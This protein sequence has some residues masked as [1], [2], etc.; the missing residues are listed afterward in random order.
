[1]FSIIIPSYNRKEYIPDLLNSLEHQ[2]AHNFE[3]V[4]VDDCSKEPVEIKHYYS[5]PI[6]LIRNEQNKGAAESRN[7]GARCA[8]NEW[9][10]FLD[11]DDRFALEK[12]EILE[13]EIQQ[14]PSVNFIYHPADCFMVN[15]NFSYIT[16]PVS[17][18]RELSLDMMLK[19]NQIGGMP[20]IGMKRELFLAVD[21]LSQ[22]IMSLEDYEFLLKLIQEPSFKAKY[23]EQP[24]TK[25]TFHTKRSS[26]ST[27]TS[28]T[29][30]AI[31]QIAKKHVRTAQQEKNFAFN[32]LYMLAYP[33]IMNLSRKAGIYYLRMF[34]HSLS[35]KYLIIALITF[36]SP[37][38]AINMKRFV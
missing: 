6:N 2:T 4:I 32:S 1:M 21:G 14:D 38:L 20:M 15:E 17:N 19:V 9:L 12:C 22:D 26:V 16:H 36:I 25:C 10:L 35:V 23:V 18:E 5:F 33:N 11:D 28:N 8:K 31:K 3:V 24:L 27:N 34:A 30:K 13:K 37:T 29:E 7:I